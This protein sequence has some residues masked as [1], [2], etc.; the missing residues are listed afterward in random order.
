MDSSSS[1]RSYTIVFKLDIILYAENTSN[2]KALLFYKVAQ[3]CIQ[4]WKKQKNKFE[5]I[6][7][8]QSININQVH[9]LS[10]RGR[11]AKYPELEEKLL[12]YVQN[13]QQEKNTVT[14]SMIERKAKEFG[15]NLNLE[16]TKFS[17]SWVEHFK[18]QHKLVEHTRTQVTQKLPEDMPLVI[19]DFLKILYKKTVNI[20]KKFI[21]SFDETLMCLG[22][23]ASGDKLLPTMKSTYIPRVIQAMTNVFFKNKGVIFVD[24]YHSHVRDDVVKAFNMKGLD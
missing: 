20:E 17:R 2:Y 3:K 4:K 6:R 12:A 13:K 7:N 18:K 14:T 21:L 5:A 9:A 19:K 23:T 22:Y 16:D 24:R 15:K 10:G 11:K 8:D 1:K